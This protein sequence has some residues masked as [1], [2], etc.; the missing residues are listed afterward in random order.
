MTDTDI[1]NPRRLEPPDGR[2]DGLTATEAFAALHDRI[3]A[4]LAAKGKTMT[5][6]AFDRYMARKLVERGY[7]GQDV[8]EAVAAKGSLAKIASAAVA[9]IRASQAVELARQAVAT[10]M[11]DG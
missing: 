7:A 3:T 2:V 11:A 8:V 1:V 9:R 10:G 6:E 5:P 4:A